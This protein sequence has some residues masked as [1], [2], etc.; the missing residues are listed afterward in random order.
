MTRAEQLAAYL[1]H[2]MRDVEP[3]RGYEVTELVDAILEITDKRTF[4]TT[5]D[6]GRR[7]GRS[8]N[9]L[10]TWRDRGRK[11]LPE[12]VYRTAQ[13]PLWDEED[14]LVWMALHPEE[15]LAP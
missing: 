9:T 4:V 11:D 2:L 12:A 7:I 3:V 15:V 5:A 10:I 13:G 14:V 6:F 8:P 1:S